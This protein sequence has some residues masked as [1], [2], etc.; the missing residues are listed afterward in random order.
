MAMIVPD[1]ITRPN[2]TLYRPRRVIA[3]EVGGDG[4][5]DG[6]LVLGTHDQ[7]RA[8]ALAD[9]VARS[10]AGTGFAAADPRPGWYRDGFE[11]GE[12]RWVSD[13]ARGRAGVWFCDIVEVTP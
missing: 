4:I 11:A 8:K 3:Y 5:T 6:V 2:G 7:H 12:R 13:E 9:Q 1:P 10:V